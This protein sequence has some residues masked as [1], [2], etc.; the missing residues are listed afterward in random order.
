MIEGKSGGQ[1]RRSYCSPQANLRSSQDESVY[2]SDFQSQKGE[3][4]LCQN[5]M[6]KSAELFK[7]LE[8]IEL[9]RVNQADLRL[10]RDELTTWMAPLKDHFLNNPELESEAMAIG[11]FEHILSRLEVVVSTMGKRLLT[12]AEFMTFM[13][14]LLSSEGFRPS[15]PLANTVEI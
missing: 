2:D 3:I 4:Q 7:S 11:K 1:S 13:E 6:Q 8:R 12:L 14:I 9:T 10:Y 5:L 15:L